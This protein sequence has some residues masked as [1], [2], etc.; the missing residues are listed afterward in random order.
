MKITVNNHL[1]TAIFFLLG[2]NLFSTAF[3]SDGLDSELDDFVLV[4]EFV[5]PLPSSLGSQMGDHEHEKKNPESDE[6][7]NDWTIIEGES[8]REIRNF[9]KEE[10]RVVVENLHNRLQNRFDGNDIEN[11]VLG[12]EFIQGLAKEES[13]YTYYGRFLL[14]S[15]LLPKEQLR[16]RLEE[17]KGLEKE[18]KDVQIH[19]EGMLLLST[20]SEGRFGIVKRI[21]MGFRKKLNNKKNALEKYKSSVSELVLILEDGDKKNQI[22]DFLSI[23]DG[24]IEKMSFDMAFLENELFPL[25]DFL[26]ARKSRL[27]LSLS[28]Y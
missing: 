26:Q 24:V 22:E 23:A 17:V 21:L 13:S 25:L 2:F 14:G 28:L 10:I 11:T 15:Y 9:K 12:K 1:I 7:L 16:I 27:D 3:A 20:Q 8:P 18:F 4:K 19:Y 5:K 6:M